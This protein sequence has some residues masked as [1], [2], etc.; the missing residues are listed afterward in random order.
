MSSTQPVLAAPNPMMARGLE[1]PVGRRRLRGA[2]LRWAIAFIAPYAAVLL[3]FVVYPFGYALWMAARPS[4]YSDLFSDPLYLTTLVNTALFVAFGVNLKMFL[5]L[6][7]S[8]FFLRRRW[9]IRALLVPF[10]LP[11]LIATAQA[12]VSFHWMLIDQR[13]L[14]DGLLSALFGIDGPIWFN[15]R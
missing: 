12:C 6:L 9:W 10:I 11:W 8:G 2:E 1:R 7:L 14:L 15:H 13:G 3:A 5:A 4:L